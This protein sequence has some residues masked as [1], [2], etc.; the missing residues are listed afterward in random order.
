MLGVEYGSFEVKA[1]LKIRGFV[2]QQDYENVEIYNA[3]SGTYD[4]ARNATL[5]EV[6]R[7]K[8]APS[9]S[10][11]GILVAEWNDEPAGIVNAYV[12]SLRKEEKNFIQLL[13]FC[14]SFGTKGLPRD[15]SKEPWK[16]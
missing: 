5:E 16:A 9:F 13:G 7:W 15:L 4:D 14:L 12:D 6:K 1:L 11:D 2:K 10:T 8:E 3:T